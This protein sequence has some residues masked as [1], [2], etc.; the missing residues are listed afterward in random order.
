MQASH[1]RWSHPALSWAVIDCQIRH[2]VWI[3]TEI[4][5]PLLPFSAEMTVSPRANA[6]VRGAAGR[7]RGRGRAAAGGR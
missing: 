2:F 1:G 6:G 3:Y 4:L 5:L 7:R